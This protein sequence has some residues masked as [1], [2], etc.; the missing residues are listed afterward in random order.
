M[1]KK[2]NNVLI[3]D[4]KPNQLLKAEESI[5]N[6]KAGRKPIPI[7][8]RGTEMI[9]IKVTS[10]QKKSIQD[11]AGLVPIATFIKDILQKADIF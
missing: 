4:K 5:G 6:K 3:I 7:E 9:S 11:K 10:E 8:K 1:N 2:K